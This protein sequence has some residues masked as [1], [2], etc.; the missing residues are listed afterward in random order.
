[1][2][3]NRP[4][5]LYLVTSSEWGGAERYV[6]VLA[7]AALASY[8]VLVAAGPSKTQELF[9]ALPPEI[10]TFTIP[11]LKSAITPL[12]DLKTVAVLR[13]LIDR[14]E[15]DLVHCNSSKAGL[16][17]VLAAG[18]SRR[19]PK[20]IYTAHGWGFLERRSPLFRLAV[21]V[22][23]LLAGRWRQAT[24]VLSKA[25][26]RVARQWHLA[27]ENRLRLI[28]H[29]LDPDEINFLPREVAHKRL[30]EMAGRELG[31]T[32]GTIANAYPAKALHV[33][34]EAFSRA[35]LDAMSF[36]NEHGGAD[37]VILGDGPL[38]DRIRAARE[39]S[40]AKERIHLL[41][42]VSQAATFLK[43]FDLFA[44]SSTK[45]GLPF[46]V[47]EA[48]LAGVPIVATKVG[49]LPE[50]ITDGEEGL[51]VP[52]D[53][54][55]ALAKAFRRVIGDKELRAKLRFGSER[56]AARHS[57]AAMIQATLDTYAEVLGK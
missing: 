19:R 54:A 44:L 7:T 37:L 1:M 5:I 23:E 32:I 39:A 14:E 9:S 28:P 6:L 3:Q 41:G 42:R 24:I 18:T 51:L 2:S 56:L 8:D 46:A 10:R 57:G 47:L 22:S 29:G 31:V 20:V 38:M 27:P 16:L 13:R 49:A 35:N 45:E 33:L 40:P 17:G 4:K 30:S 55:P 43:G 34:I 48:A 50:M 25:E 36:A 26:R 15:I 53:D 52:P 12:R 11:G 21:L